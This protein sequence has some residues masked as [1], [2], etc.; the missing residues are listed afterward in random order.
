MNALDTW[1]PALYP[2]KNPPHWSKYWNVPGLDSMV[3]CN[4]SKL[5]NML[6]GDPIIQERA[7]LKDD[8]NCYGVL[9]KFT[10]MTMRSLEWMPCMKLSTGLCPL[11]TS[12][13][14]WTALHPHNL[15]WVDSLLFLD[16][17]LK[18]VRSLHSCLKVNVFKRSLS[19]DLKP[20][21]HVPKLMLMSDCE[22]PCYVSIVAKMKNWSLVKDASTGVSQLIAS[23]PS[24]GKVLLLWS[25]FNLTP[26]LAMLT[27]TGLLM[28]QC[29]LELENIM[30]NV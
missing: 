5:M 3:R 26:T 11:S 6:D 4:N 16:W 24:S 19:A 10:W 22:E 18:S 28:E 30:W 17:C 25:Q 2:M 7:L 15:Q 20:N 13:P 9:L 29:W 8:I 1:L 12:T 27:H 14:L 23:I 21:K